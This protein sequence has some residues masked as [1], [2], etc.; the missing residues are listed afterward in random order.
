MRDRL[1]E[2]EMTQKTSLRGE[3]GV[4]LGSRLVKEARFLAGKKINKPYQ[5]KTGDIDEATR[6]RDAVD[7][8]WWPSP[9]A[10]LRG[11]DGLLAACSQISRRKHAM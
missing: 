5:P 6:T 7:R 2:W 4:R 1:P 8:F 9:H 10:G 11:E 3:R